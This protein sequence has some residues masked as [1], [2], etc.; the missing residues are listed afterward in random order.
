MNQPFL[1]NIRALQREVKARAVKSKDRQATLA[2]HQIRQ[3][4]FATRQATINSMRSLPAKCCEVYGKGRKAFDEG[5]IRR[6]VLPQLGNLLSWDFVCRTLSKNTPTS[7]LAIATIVPF[8]RMR[9]G[10]AIAVPA[11]VLRLS[12]R[13][14]SQYEDQRNE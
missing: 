14:R 13:S 2:L 6:Q 4:L 1:R 11:V 10:I 9:H 12:A 3:G 8:K 5:I 7:G